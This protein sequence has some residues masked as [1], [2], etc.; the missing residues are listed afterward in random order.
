MASSI[1]TPTISTSASMVMLLSVKLSE[2]I[3][4][5]VEMIEAG[6]A[7][8]AMIVAR[9]L[10]MNSSTTSDARIEPRIRCSLHFVKSRF[11][12]ARLVLHDFEL[13]ARRQQFAARARDAP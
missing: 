7:I 1:T 2:H 5:K 11:D 8:A 12:V 9:Q 6:I 10:R 4:P 3:A 13:H